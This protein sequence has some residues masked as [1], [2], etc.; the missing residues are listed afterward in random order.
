VALGEKGEI[1]RKPVL[2]KRIGNV[3]CGMEENS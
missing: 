1:L 3:N 2:Q